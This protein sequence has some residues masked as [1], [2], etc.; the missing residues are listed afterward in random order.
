MSFWDLEDGSSATADAKGDF[1][2]GGGNFAPIPDGSWVHAFVEEAKW[3]STKD[4]D[5][6][7]I[8]LKWSVEDPDQ[9][10]NRKVFQKLFVTDLD[11]GAKDTAKAKQKRDKARK[12][13]ANIDANSGG[14]LARKSSAP[15]DDELMIA[16]Q[17]KVMAIR[18]AVW[19][20]AGNS[21]NWVSAVSDRRSR[22]VS[23]PE[24]KSA[25]KSG[26]FQN[27]LDD[28]IPF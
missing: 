17:G 8:S 21:G 25:G 24:V 20:M 23:I 14:K 4:D 6:R 2:A 28:D 16:L 18:L 13:L 22:P 26:G 9:F 12:M 7:F 15:S 19:D 3:Q 11:P 1:E 27:D 5:A 10:H